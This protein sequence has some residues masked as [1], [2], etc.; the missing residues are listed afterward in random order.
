MIGTTRETVTNQLNRFRR[1]GL[2]WAHRRHLVVN[3]RRMVDYVQSEGSWRDG[4]GLELAK[5]A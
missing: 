1:M 4:E 3:R 5:S 2:V